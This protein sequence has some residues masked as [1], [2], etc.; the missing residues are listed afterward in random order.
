MAWSK[1]RGGTRFIPPT[2]E[3]NRGGGRE[4]DGTSN[5]TTMGKIYCGR[6]SA[7]VLGPRASD[8]DARA[9]PS[10]TGKRVV[11]TVEADLRPHKSVAGA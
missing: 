11:K 6:G 7:D 5:T 2:M 8:S 9:H 1:E 4:I 3:S 10:M